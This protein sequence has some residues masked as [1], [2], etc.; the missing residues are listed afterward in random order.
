MQSVFRGRVYG[1]TFGCQPSEVWVRTSGEISHF[2]WK[3][4]RMIEKIE[5]EGAA[6]LQG[7]RFDSAG[8]RSGHRHAKNAKLLGLNGGVRL[9]SA[10]DGS[11][12]PVGPDLEGILAGSPAI[13]SAARVALVPLTAANKVTV[14]SL[15]GEPR[16]HTIAVGKAPFAAVINAAGTA[17][18]S[19]T[20]AEGFRSPAT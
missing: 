7:I 11:A 9:F 8:N 10:S 12:R 14:M 20:G 15:Q 6:G 3:S 5:T 18:M 13:A 1:V 4:N 16:A 19:R 2:D 17:A